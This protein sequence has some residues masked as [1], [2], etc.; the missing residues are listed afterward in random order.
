VHQ[1]RFR[2]ALQRE[3]RVG[4]FTINRDVSYPAD[5]VS[6]HHRAIGVVEQPRCLKHGW[7]EVIATVNS[8]FARTNRYRNR[9]SG[10]PLNSQGG[11]RHRL[12]DSS[13]RHERICAAPEMDNVSGSVRVKDLPATCFDGFAAGAHERSELMGLRLKPGKHHRPKLSS[14]SRMLARSNFPA[15]KGPHRPA[16]IGRNRRYLDQRWLGDTQPAPGREVVN[17]H[18][19]RPSLLLYICGPAQRRQRTHCNLTCV[20]ESEIA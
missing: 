3:Q 1:D 8:N 15:S 13:R 17:K 7:A 19:V 11:A 9:S 20:I 5:S 12:A 10:A 16:L 4:D 6:K 18:L 14:A 2:Y